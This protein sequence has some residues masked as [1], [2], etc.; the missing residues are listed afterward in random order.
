MSAVDCG[1]CVNPVLGCSPR[2][3]RAA[4]AGTDDDQDGDL[5]FDQQL[6]AAEQIRLAEE[7]VAAVNRLVDGQFH[8]ATDV[9]K[10]AVFAQ[11]E[12]YRALHFARQVPA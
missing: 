10:H 5:F 12:C 6:P 2:C 3:A 7:A 11:T 1:Q 8:L 9:L 4:Q